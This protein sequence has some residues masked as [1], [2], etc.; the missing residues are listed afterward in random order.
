MVQARRR[1]AEEVVVLA[2]QHAQVPDVSHLCFDLEYFVKWRDDLNRNHLATLLLEKTFQ[3]LAE[4]VASAVFGGDAL[5]VDG[6]RFEPL[7]V[8]G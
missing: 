7:G 1:A 8:F 6:A 2:I 3:N 4:T 5:D